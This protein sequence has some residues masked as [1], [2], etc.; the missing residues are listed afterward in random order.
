MK[1]DSLFFTTAVLLA[2]PLVLMPLMLTPSGALAQSQAAQSG[3]GNGAASQVRCEPRDAK[4]TRPN[5]LRTALQQQRQKCDDT[6][7]SNAAGRHLSTQ[8]K[9]QLREQLRQQR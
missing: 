1:K 5:D 7:E 3:T 2:A 4:D 8:E 6:A 9:A